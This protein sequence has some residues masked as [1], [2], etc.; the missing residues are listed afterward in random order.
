M[1]TYVLQ[2]HEFKIA[3]AGN[4]ERLAIETSRRINMYRGLFDQMNANDDMALTGFPNKLSLSF[5]VVSLSF[6]TVSAV[7]AKGTKTPHR[8]FVLFLSWDK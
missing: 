5:G 8:M 4:A 3:E 2:F 1:F 6:P 7:I